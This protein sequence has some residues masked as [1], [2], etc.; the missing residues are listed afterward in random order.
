MLE[1]IQIQRLLDIALFGCHKGEVGLA[2]QV[3]EGLDQV[4]CDSPELEIC[5]AMSFY[6]VNQFDQA[7]EVLTKAEASFGDNLMVKTHKGIVQSLMGEK[8]DA[9][10][11]LEAVVQNSHD[12]DA[13]TLASA[14]LDEA[15]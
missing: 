10:K 11:T 8:D 1:Q 4:L 9:R 7:M 13:V 12:P 6:T 15:L 5:R 3:I 14:F 2:R